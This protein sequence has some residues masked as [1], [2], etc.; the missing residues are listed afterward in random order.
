[1]VYNHKQID[2]KWQHYWDKHQSFK[3]LEDTQKEKKYILDMF[4]YPSAQG[5]H[6]GHP[7]GYTATDIFSRFK[8]MQGY[9]V[10]H[11][12]GWDAFGLPAEQYA[13]Q[14]GNHPDAF[15]QENIQNFKRQIKSLGFSYDWERE[16]STTDPDYYQWTQWIF[17]QLYRLGLAEVK[18]IE[19][20]WCEGL[21]TVLANEEV[22]NK[23]G[24]MVS[25]RGEFPVVK[26]PM[27]QWILK[28]THYAERLLEDLDELDW[29]ESI[30]D[31]QRH[32]IG[33]SQGAL[34]TYHVKDIE[35]TFDVFTT[36]PDTLFGVSYVVLAPEHPLV[37]KITTQAQM[38]A[39]EAYRSVAASKTDLERAEINKDKTGAFT[40]AFALCPLTKREI[41]I[42]ISDY[43]LASYGTGAV[44]A[45]PAH[46]TRDFEFATKF[47]LPMIPVIEG[48]NGKEAYIKDGKH[49]DSELLNGLDNKQAIETIITY[50]EE[51]GVGKKQINYKLRDWIF[52]RQ[53]YWGEPFPVVHYNDGSVGLM[54]EGSLPLTLPVM[55]NIKPSGD[56]QSPLVNATQ[57]LNVMDE[58]G[59]VIGKRDTN[60]MPQWAGSCW[61]YCGYILKRP[62]SM[63]PLNSEQAKQELAKWLPVDLYI[64]GA[65]HAVLHLLYS[66]FWHK[67]LFDIGVV[68]TKEPYQRLF[69]QGMILGEN[70]EKM[71]KSKGNVV[72][73]DIIVESHGADAF[74]LYE[75]F[76]GPLE[77]SVSWSSEGVDGARRF[78]DRVWRL[79]V[80]DDCLTTKLTTV[81]D[82]SLDRV[83]HETVKKVTHD[84]ETL[85]FNTAIA[86]M[87]KFINE[88]YKVE[89]LYIPYIEGFLT[90]LN[91]IA[92]HLTEELWEML[93]HVESMTYQP[94][95]T[96]DEAMLA[97]DEIEVVIQVN[98]KVRAKVV[99]PNGSSD[100]LLKETALKQ[101][102]VLVHLEGKTV[103]KVIVIK[104]RLV[105]IVVK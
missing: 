67:V 58:S 26:K 22:I 95:P 97:Q 44:M 9:N 63:I 54:D 27:K 75:M 14:T 73:P 35:A 48:F 30:K 102:N 7:E 96:Y 50:L 11:P 84:F 28:I 21:G 57:W 60:T 1:M 4:P 10:L 47:G 77:A 42:W 85:G 100:D 46:D 105:N 8:R 2:Q 80:Q 12:M 74:R 83:Y 70:N 3:V 66:R 55:T 36:R 53:R 76:M 43:V 87:M 103:M 39:V 79:L 82:Q 6:V 25:E 49:I 93:G 52:A 61:Y 5:L 86:Q 101:H 51:K 23:D 62:G 56:G 65:E 69:N 15:T 90:L 89:T 91:P 20:N 64:G 38:E 41:P 40:G 81:N 104:G 32:W 99:M 59:H 17:M 18:E 98:G 31:M 68:Q 88:C 24:V 45:V 29:P 37:M 78:L 71:S 33:K 34:V 72:N 92:P 16:L 13:I 94:W 19:V